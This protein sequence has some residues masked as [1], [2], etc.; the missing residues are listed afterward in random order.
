MLY[1]EIPSTL[2]VSNEQITKGEQMFVAWDYKGANVKYLPCAFE[3]VYALN[4]A[5][6][7]LEDSLYKYIPKEFHVYNTHDYFNKIQP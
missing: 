2:Y 1:K 6:N 7:M 5:M 4:V 3:G